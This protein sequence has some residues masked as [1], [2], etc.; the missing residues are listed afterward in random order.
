MSLF[1]V[2]PDTVWNPG[3][4]RFSSAPRKILQRGMLLPRLDFT[5]G[6][7][8]RV[9]FENQVLR[10]L[11]ALGPFVAAILI[12][13]DLA[14]PISQA[15]V[16]MVLAIAFVELRVLRVPREKR[17]RLMS[18]D[19]V[20]RTLDTLNFRGRRILARLAASRGLE[21]GGLYL[22]VEQSDM[23]KVAPLTAVS[24][25]ADSGKSRLVS[26]SDEERQIIRDDLFDDS[27]TERQLHIANLRE[28]VG[29]RSVSF[30][31]R[32]VSAHARLAARLSQ[33]PVPEER[34]A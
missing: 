20:A 21:H 22:V 9:I 19:A 13:P 4:L 12:W 6:L 23:A 17:A 18:E 26:L 31:A 27:F 28:N 2:T 14:L 24:V 30:D 33:A 25:Q 32:G 11:V 34:P 29:I 5:W 15:P 1:V 10:Y 16:P 3:A 7:L 8:A